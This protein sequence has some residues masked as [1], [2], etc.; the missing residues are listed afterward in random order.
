MTKVYTVY[1]ESHKNLYNNYFL[2][3]LPKD[4]DVVSHKIPQN[5][6]SANFYETGWA[7][8]CFKKT[9]I[10]LRACEEN[11]NDIFVFSDVDIQFFTNSI[12]E[13]LLVELQDYDLACQ[14]DTGFLPYCS[15]FFIC[16]SNSRT[17]D[18]FN[19]INQKY[20]REDQTSLNCYINKCKAKFLSNKFYTVA[21]SIGT[22]W[23]GQ[24]FNIPTNI[25][26][27]HANWVVGVDNKIV[28]LDLVRKKYESLPKLS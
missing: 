7:D 25:V 3:T 19:T 18:L 21:Q 2:K 5:C 6:P 17:L 16:R 1:S 27:H 8:T 4:L 24:D 20:I 23:S 22:V 15:G 13:D 26:L 14:F 10:F 9:E 28:L 12:V 11:F